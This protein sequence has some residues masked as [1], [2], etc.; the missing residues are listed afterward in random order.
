MEFVLSLLII[1]AV[2]LVILVVIIWVG[3]DS[4]VDAIKEKKNG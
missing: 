3:V 1:I 2:E 4:I